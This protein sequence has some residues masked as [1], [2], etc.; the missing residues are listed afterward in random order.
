MATTVRSAQNAVM[1]HRSDRDALRGNLYAV[2]VPALM[3]ALNDEIWPEDALQLMGDAVL[4][5]ARARVDAAGP[6]GHRC[7]AALRDRG[8]EGDHELADQID[9]M[10][11]VAPTPFLKSLP[12]DLEELAGILEG[13]PVMG[14]GR[15]DLRTGEVWPQSAIEYLEEVGEL[16]PDEDDDQRWLDVACEGSRAS[17]R[18]MEMFIGALGDGRVADRLAQAIHGR[19]AFRRFKDALADSD[20][21]LARWYGLSDDRHRG[22]ARAW[23]ADEGYTPTPTKP[24]DA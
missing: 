8:W 20:D 9:A 17:Y 24:S 22:R 6:A 23:L 14:G 16:D 18:D 5:V 15:I 1:G 21:L 3:D 7:A 11:G 13:D 19:G 2:D 10:L 4:V 12:V